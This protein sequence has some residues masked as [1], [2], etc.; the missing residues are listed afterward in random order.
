MNFE[1][2]M[3]RKCP[4]TSLSCRNF[5]KPSCQLCENMIVNF[6]ILLISEISVPCIKEWV[7]IGI[8]FPTA[9]FDPSTHCDI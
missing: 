2:F 5:Q 7:N 8:I 1:D 4:T 3:N 6:S 9:S